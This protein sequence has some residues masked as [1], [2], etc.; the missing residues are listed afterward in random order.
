[1]SIVK[2]LSVGEGDMFYIR[3]N[4]DNFT[5]IDCCVEEEWHKQVVEELENAA[6]GKII[7]RFIST[8]PDDDHIRG[9]KKLCKDFEIPNFYCVANKALN[10]DGEEDFDMYCKLRD[11]SSCFY[12][13]QG[14]S[15]KWMNLNSNPGDD[16]QRQS[17]GINILWPVVK[18]EKYQEVLKAVKDWQDPNNMSPIIRYEAEGKKSFI[19]FGDMENSFQ[20]KIKNEIKLPRTDVVFAPHHGRKSGHLVS[21]WL[22]ELEPKVIIVGEAPSEHLDYYRGYDTITQNTA[23]DITFV[24]EN[25]QI[26]IYVGEKDYDPD[27]TKLKNLEKPLSLVNHRYNPRYGYYVG[28]II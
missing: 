26:D 21:E 11:G 4:S 20:E 24:C 13:E 10:P 28:T 25:G 3:H 7:K 2:S 16:E 9:L 6:S 5:I 19:W 17:A 14:C 27:C 23:G 15:R 22:Q 18:N 12:L 8:H 1:M